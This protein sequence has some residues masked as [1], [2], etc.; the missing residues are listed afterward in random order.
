MVSDQYSKENWLIR[1]YELGEDANIHTFLRQFVDPLFSELCEHPDVS[2]HHF[3]LNGDV[4][5]IRVYPDSDDVSELIDDIEEEQDVD[6]VQGKWPNRDQDK[7]RVGG[8]NIHI[9]DR[10]REFESRVAVEAAKSE[11]SD[12]HRRGLLERGI[13]IFGNN[14]G[15]YLDVNIPIEPHEEDVF[16][17]IWKR[18]LDTPW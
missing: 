10:K 1:G 9:I 7:E 15:I 8:D 16:I 11:L 12:K 2:T 3:N 6:S 4:V 13:H 14:M 17:G 18:D 5:N